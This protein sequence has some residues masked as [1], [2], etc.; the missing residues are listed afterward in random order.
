MKL[1]GNDMNKWGSTT[2]NLPI[3]DRNTIHTS[4]LDECG[5]LLS[6]MKYEFTTPMLQKVMDL[7]LH[8]QSNHV[9]CKFW[10]DTFPHILDLICNIINNSIIIPFFDGVAYVSQCPIN[11]RK[12]F[13][14]RF[15]VE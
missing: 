10:C 1:I 9:T 5:M 12:T 7:S 3:V 2:Q 13:T 4:I 8:L 11:L 6:W 14:Y 15:K